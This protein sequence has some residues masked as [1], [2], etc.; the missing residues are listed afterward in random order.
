MCNRRRR[1][2]PPNPWGKV[3]NSRLVMRGDHV[4]HWM[5][6]EKVVDASLK[7][8]AVAA[9]MAKR[10]GP[11]SPVYDMLVNQP[12]RRCPISLQEPWRRRVAQKYQDPGIAVVG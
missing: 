5:N 10:W 9:A 3:N 7:S 8:P 12:R 11:A 1:E 6:G 4:E 2:T